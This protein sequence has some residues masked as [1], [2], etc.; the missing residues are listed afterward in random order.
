MDPQCADIDDAETV[1]NGEV[2]LAP[3]KK[4][5]EKEPT[6]RKSKLDTSQTVGFL[7]F[8]RANRQR[9]FRDHIAF[10]SLSAAIAQQ[11]AVSV[12]TLDELVALVSR[13]VCEVI[14][15]VWI[16]EIAERLDDDES[17]AARFV[18]DAEFDHRE[19]LKFRSKYIA[20]LVSM[21]ASEKDNVVV[22][23]L[24]D[25]EKKWHCLGMVDAG[26]DGAA[27]V[28]WVWQSLFA[29]V[30]QQLESKAVVGCLELLNF[31]ELEVRP[32][33][34]PEL[35]AQVPETEEADD[36]DGAAPAAAQAAIHVEAGPENLA[37]KEENKENAAA[38]EAN[39]AANIAEN[40]AAA[41]P[42]ESPKSPSKRLRGKKSGPWKEESA[43]DSQNEAEEHAALGGVQADASGR[44]VRYSVA[45]SQIRQQWM[46]QFTAEDEKPQSMN[47]VRRL[48]TTT[49]GLA[50]D[51][52]DEQRD[53]SIRYYWNQCDKS[54][55]K[56]IKQ[57]E[58]QY[59][60]KQALTIN[61]SLIFAG[62][63]LPEMQPG[64][65]PVGPSK[66]EIH[67]TMVRS[68][69]YLAHAWNIPHGEN[70]TLDLVAVDKPVMIQLGPIKTP[71][72]VKVWK[73]VPNP[74]AL[75][76]HGGKKNFP[77]VRPMFA[78]EEKDQKSSMR[79]IKDRMTTDIAFRDFAFDVAGFDVPKAAEQSGGGQKNK[80]G[81]SRK[82][83]KGSEAEKDKTDSG[84]KETEK[85]PDKDKVEDKTDQKDQ[86]Q[87]PFA[88]MMDCTYGFGS[89]N[90][91]II[92]CHVFLPLLFSILKS[93]RGVETDTWSVML[94][95]S[96]FFVCLSL[97]LDSAISAPCTIFA[98]SR[99]LAIL[100]DG[101]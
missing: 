66:P 9:S 85:D 22:K 79:K 80:K 72:T 49:E 42:Q 24:T 54:T 23:Q 13:Q 16:T 41:E 26:T 17:S 6:P 51:D 59:T 74:E 60:G 11:C 88:H 25:D 100:G 58:A 71:A 47:Q 64:G 50:W 36:A 76:K 63:V 62:E 95:Y 7:D 90:L 53:W 8:L 21:Y 34:G 33:L 37:E 29:F 14:L 48:A 46:N 94:S 68:W 40:N 44:G 10:K 15:P 82:G 91:V 86:K 84:E 81:G 70:P 67:L 4:A 56:E 35:G 98:V 31:I 38:S 75:L 5:S 83:K 69:K 96:T 73:L 101:D 3:Q 43:K 87:H 61:D 92:T 89:F 2:A 97:H 39:V 19:F 45:H 20:S 28:E 93:Q 99:F 32:A 30:A 65:L 12:P 57:L 77:L 52:F 1:G 27:N 55:A 78:S 18:I